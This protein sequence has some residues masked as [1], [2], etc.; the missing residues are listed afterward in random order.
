M[1]EAQ[2]NCL[3][4]T[5]LASEYF[6]KQQMAVDGPLGELLKSVSFGGGAQL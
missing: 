4:T 6:L 1:T 5:Y 3:R 2:V